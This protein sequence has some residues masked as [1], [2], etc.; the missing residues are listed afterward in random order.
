MRSSYCCRRAIA[1][2]RSTD[3]IGAG[4]R[5]RH[6]SSRSRYGIGDPGAVLVHMARVARLLP[7][8]ALRVRSP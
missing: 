4:K 3:R 2:D 5:G 7:A 1:R 6:R 8:L